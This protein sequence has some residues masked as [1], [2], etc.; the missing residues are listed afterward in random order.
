MPV[1]IQWTQRAAGRDVGDQETVELTPFVQ[2]CLDQGRVFIVP[3]PAVAPEAHVFPEP[4]V[5]ALAPQLAEVVGD[6]P[7]AD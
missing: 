6:Q 4:A 2:G 3:D 5:E 1:T 7:P